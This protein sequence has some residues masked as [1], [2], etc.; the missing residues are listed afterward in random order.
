[1]RTSLDPKTRAAPGQGAR[2]AMTAL[3]SAARVASAGGEQR[4]EKEN[5]MATTISNKTLDNPG[6]TVTHY[7]EKADEVRKLIEAVRAAIPAIDVPADMS[8]NSPVPT[9]K[10]SF[11]ATAAGMYDGSS[12]LQ[13]FPA[14]DV[15]DAEDTLQYMDA[16]RPVILLL[17]SQ[18]RH[19]KLQFRARKKAASEKA[20]RVY[21]LAKAVQRVTPGADLDAHLG[22]LKAQLGR[23]KK[24][25]AATPKTPAPPA[26]TTDP[27]KTG[28]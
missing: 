22:S 10:D 24:A 23:R 14:I 9:L 16:F 2:E 26:S 1:V 3:P 7:R 12:D 25:R 4:E 21:D 6:A 5:I 28:K 11:I 20:L 18:I 17:E 15:N 13:T 8:L 19:I 27:A